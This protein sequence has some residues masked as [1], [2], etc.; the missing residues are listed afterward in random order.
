MAVL[1]RCR[2][3]HRR[4]ETQ[5]VL[6]ARRWS[7][8]LADSSLLRARA[9]PHYTAAVKDVF[10]ASPLGGDEWEIMRAQCAASFNVPH[11]R[12]Y[13][14][15]RASGEAYKR[16]SPPPYVVARIQVS[17][18]CVRVWA[19]VSVFGASWWSAPCL[20]I[21]EPHG[22]GLCIGLGAF[23]SFRERRSRC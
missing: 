4:R 7:R 12:T 5:K 18:V 23:C 21:R 19:N 16:A 15:V 13:T 8:I 6:D 2:Y 20:C 10:R 3:K 1:V 9:H 17:V 14:H 22:A 11:T